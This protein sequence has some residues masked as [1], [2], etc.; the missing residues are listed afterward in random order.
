MCHYHLFLSLPLSLT[1]LGNR[2]LSNK[3]IHEWNIHI[4]KQTFANVESWL[5][6]SYCHEKHETN[7]LVNSKFKIHLVCKSTKQ[8]TG[9]FFF[10]G[11]SFLV[12]QS[13]KTYRG[14]SGCQHIPEVLTQ[15]FICH[16]RG[17]LKAD[18]L[19]A[20][21]TEIIE[22]LHL[23][24]LWTSKDYFLSWKHNS[25]SPCMQVTGGSYFYS[26]CHWSL[27]TH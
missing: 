1:C 21:L 5:H 3:N 7:N 8:F 2:F 10:F 27:Y 18:L 25:V 17:K 13:T 15:I 14:T 20:T 4:S 9:L 23:A 24:F 11:F 12:K 6:A 22:A 16:M 26:I 19:L